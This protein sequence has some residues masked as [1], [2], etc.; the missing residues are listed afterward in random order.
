MKP[1]SQ[2]SEN[3][4]L[5]IFNHLQAILRDSQRVL[6]IGSGTA[7]HAVFF[8]QKMPWIFWQTSDRLEYHAGINAWCKEFPAKNLGLPLQLDVSCDADWM[9]L[10]TQQGS[11]LFDAVFT[12]NTAHIMS[13]EDVCEMFAGISVILKNNQNFVIYGPFNRDGQFTS[14]S[15]AQFD[16][17]LRMQNP[18]MGIRNDVEL[19]SLGEKHDLEMTDDI[20]MPAN[21]RLLVFSKN[22]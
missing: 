4:K 10:S 14:T 8:A 11:Q 15:N 6:E 3:N 5:A 2:A 21:N 19:A 18:L 17:S 13:W 9:R 16:A 7:Q 1:F 20:T 12:A 22:H